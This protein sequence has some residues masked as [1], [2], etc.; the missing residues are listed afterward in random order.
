[1]SAMT[2]LLQQALDAVTRLDDQAQN[3]IATIILD[4]L[5]EDKKWDESFARTES[6]LA[7]LAQKARAD[8]A[9]GRAREGGFDDL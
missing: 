1:M 7:L 3:A 8:V 6:K 9:A 4:E 2:Q 5:A